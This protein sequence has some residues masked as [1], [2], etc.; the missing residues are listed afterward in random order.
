MVGLVGFG[1][2]ALF[3]HGWRAEKAEIVAIYIPRLFWHRID[4]DSR[5]LFVER[6]RAAYDVPVFRSLSGLRRETARWGVSGKAFLR[7]GEFEP[8]MPGQNQRSD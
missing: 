5:P 3:Q 7:G 8:P 6:L 1:S 4:K 2:V